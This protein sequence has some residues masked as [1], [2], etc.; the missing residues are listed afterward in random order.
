MQQKALA[1]RIDDF[2]SDAAA[3][4]KRS[5]HVEDSD[6]IDAIA[7]SYPGLRPADLDGEVCKQ[8]LVLLFVA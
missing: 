4:V 7:M 5:H 1:S 2:D 8:R 6:S 3:C